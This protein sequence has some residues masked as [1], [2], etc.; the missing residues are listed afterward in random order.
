MLS[1]DCGRV[2][3]PLPF[4]SAEECTEDCAALDSDNDWDWARQADGVDALAEVV[5]DPEEA[6][7]VAL[8]AGF[9][10][11]DL[12]VFS[13]A[14]VFWERVVEGI[15]DG[16]TEGGIGAL[17]AEAA[18][19]YPHNEV[20]AGHRSQ[21]RGDAGSNAS[22]LAPAASRFGAVDN[23][24]A[25]IGQQVIVQGNATFGSAAVGDEGASSS[26]SPGAWLRWP[27]SRRAR[28]GLA[29]LIGG[30]TL[31][32]AVPMVSPGARRAVC[33]VPGIRS[34][35]AQEPSAAEQAQWQRALETSS[36]DGLREYLRAY[37]GGVHVEEARARIDG[38]RSDSRIEWQDDTLRSER[39]VLP[40][41]EPQATE[42]DARRDSLARAQEDV[43][44]NACISFGSS[45]LFRLRSTAFEPTRWDCRPR[46]GG[47]LCTVHGHAVCE[48]QRRKT[49]DTE[50]CNEAR[51]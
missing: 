15:V 16:K 48:V 46:G 44:K 10:R 50:I 27:R 21:A 14:R 51:E 38:C 37:P 12:P 39:T 30:L 45:A 42:E 18:K 25:S 47:H 36:G 11:K 1:P 9:P 34:L 32:V 3:E 43:A 33:R 7:L 8:G 26:A 28:R 2:D 20:F 17:V 24:G 4:A 22:P 41:S 40:S 31:A 23:R 6:R 13:T 49:V 29:L 35:C 19:L 5:H